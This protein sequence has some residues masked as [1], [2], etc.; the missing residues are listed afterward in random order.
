[1]QTGNWVINHLH[2]DSLFASSFSVKK[3]LL[4]S[5]V[6]LLWNAR[7]ATLGFGGATNSGF[8]KFLLHFPT[9]ETVSAYEVS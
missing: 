6:F 8:A 5:S 3:Y 2:L 9:Q 1:M 7:N 4:R